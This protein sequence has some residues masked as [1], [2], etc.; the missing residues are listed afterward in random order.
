MDEYPESNKLCI[1]KKE[2]SGY[3]PNYSSDLCNKNIDKILV[4]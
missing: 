4:E 3:L 2:Y 1:N